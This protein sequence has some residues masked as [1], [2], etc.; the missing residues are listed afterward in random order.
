MLESDLTTA[1]AVCPPSV[2]DHTHRGSKGAIAYGPRPS[3]LCSGCKNIRYCSRAHQKLDWSFHRT[4]CKQYRGLE[5]RPSPNMRR[6]LYFPVDKTMTE[7]RWLPVELKNG[8]EVPQ[9]E[10]AFYFPDNNSCYS[11]QCARGCSEGFDGT[12]H[13]KACYSILVHRGKDPRNVTSDAQ[14]NKCIE[15]LTNGE[16]KH[17]KGPVLAFGSQCLAPSACKDL[18]TTCLNA[19][20]GCIYQSVRHDDPFRSRI[21]Q[22]VRI[23]CDG[24]MKKYKLPKFQSQRIE[25]RAL[26]QALLWRAELPRLVLGKGLDIYGISTEKSLEPRNPMASLL[27]I[28]CSNNAN[29]WGYYRRQKWGNC[30]IT[31]A[32]GKPLEVDYLKTF[33]RWIEKD[34]R[35]LFVAVRTKE[36]RERDNAQ[37]GWEEIKKAHNNV[38]D[39]IT[40]QRFL[41]FSKGSVQLDTIGERMPNHLEIEADDEDSNN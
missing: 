28:P 33:C 26:G 19:V 18:D 17:W 2:S 22:G 39:K 29:T 1:C 16:I 31:R 7:F 40:L 10:E 41:D 6:V 30:L 27:V 9:W 15:Y 35:R 32:D 34:L 14:P 3:K 20:A 13:V 24:H 8:Q 12:E 21:I 11:Y 25:A 37:Y 36:S 4:V 23:N 5:P 38:I